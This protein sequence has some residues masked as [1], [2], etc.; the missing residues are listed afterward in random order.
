MP[1]PSK[2]T[3]VAA[4]GSAP[5]GLTIQDTVYFVGADPRSLGNGDRVAATRRSCLSSPWGDGSA[6]TV[7]PDPHRDRG[8]FVNSF[9]VV[10]IGSV[11]GGRTEP[12]DDAWDSVR[13]RIELDPAVVESAS[14]LGLDSFSHVEVTFVFDRVDPASVCRGA[15]H[16][17]GRQDWPLVGILAQRAKDRP[18]RIGNTICR[19]VGVGETWIDVAG[20]DAI[21]GTP[22][23]DVKPYLRGFAPRGE[24]T[25]PAWATELMAEYW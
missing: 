18:N 10:A 11:T 15:R 24:T 17:R 8:D 3:T 9:T 19:I 25:E 20:L 6:G 5:A 7:L 12:I 4:K 23:L 13:A 16:P 1:V 22:V 2:V 14:I 21:D